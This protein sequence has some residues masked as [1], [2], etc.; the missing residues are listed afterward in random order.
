MN[1]RLQRAVLALSV[2]VLAL[3][4]SVLVISL[5]LFLADDPIG[6]VWQVL[7]TAPAERNW[8]NIIDKTTIYYLSGI[9]VAIGFRMNLFNIGVEGQFLVAALMAAFV[10]GEA[11]L[12]GYLNTGVAIIAAMV[13]GGLYAGIAG[14]LRAY[15]GVSEVIS[16]IM[17]NAVAVG[18]TAFITRELAKSATQSNVS[19]VQTKLI[20]E[21]SWIPNI[22]IGDGPASEIY[23]FV[24][25]AVVA[26]FVY[27]FMINR[28]RFGFDLRATG[29]SLTAAVASGINVKR[30]TVVAMMISG[31]FAGLVGLPYIFGEYHSYGSTFPAGLGFTGIAVALIGR[32]HPIGVALGAL[33]FAFLDEQ[34]NKLQIDAG[35][36]PEIV[37]IMQGTILLMVVISS[38]VVRRYGLRLEQQHVARVLA[39]RDP[40]SPPAEGVEGAERV[41]GVDGDGTHAATTLP[42]TPGAVRDADDQ[43]EEAPL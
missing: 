23:G 31:A 14:V 33:L 29:Q 42:A 25:I 27:W 26:G 41:K 43:P 22:S 37:K 3:V 6:A 5:V 39:Q 2:P 38:E 8:A 11:W 32:N 34:S 7:R 40:A 36:S 18:L 28:T 35:V 13:A 16:T 19:V 21:E 1:I 30:M 12:P 10:A 17:L 20:P 4:L 15:R 24:V 9:A